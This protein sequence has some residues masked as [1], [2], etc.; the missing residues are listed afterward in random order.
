[1][2]IST[3]HSEDHAEALAAIKEKRPPSFKGR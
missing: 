3:F 2:E 1:M